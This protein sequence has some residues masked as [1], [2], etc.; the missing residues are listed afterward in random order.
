MI[1]TTKF[2]YTSASRAT[3]TLVHDEAAWRISVVKEAKKEKLP[4]VEIPP[5]HTPLYLPT[6]DA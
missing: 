4:P 5:M 2:H 6:G 3:V 1:G